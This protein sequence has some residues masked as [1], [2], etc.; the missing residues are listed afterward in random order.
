MKSWRTPLAGILLLVAMAPTVQG[1][2]LVQGA[3]SSRLRLPHRGAT[4]LDTESRIDANNIDMFVTNFGS[5]AYDLGNQASGLYYP[6]GS[7][8]TAVYAAGIW[9]GAKVNGEIRL[10][11]ATYGQE[12]TPGPMAG[13]TFQPDGPTFRNYKVVRDLNTNA[14]DTSAFAPYEWPRADGAPT[15]SLGRP[16]LLGDQM[17]WSVY[18]DADPSLH[19][20]LSGGTEPLGVEIQQSTFAFYNGAGLDNVVFLKYT[21][22]NKGP[23]TLDST[24]VS[25]WA[26]PDLGGFSDDLVGC[27]TTLSLGYCYNS[28]NNDAYYGDRP[29]AVGF[30]FF[31]G[32]IVQVSPGVYDTLGMTSFNKYTNGTDPLSA[33]E[34]YNYMSGLFKDGSPIYEYDN[35]AYPVTHYQVSGDPVAGD[36]WLDDTPGDRRLFLTSGP[37]TMAP[38]DTQVVVGAVIVGQGA[39]RLSSITDLRNKDRNAQLAFDTDFVQ[40]PPVPPP[41]VHA[42]PT[43]RGVHLAWGTEPVGYVGVGSGK[44]YHFEGFQVWQLEKNEPGADRR[45]LATYDIA[46]GVTSL[47]VD[48][49]NPNG[50]WQRVLKAPGADTGLEFSLDLTQDA[51]GGRLTNYREYYYAV[52]GYAYEI[53]TAEPYTA[54]KGLVVDFKESAILKSGIAV[55]TP[56]PITA[57]F[58]V[59]VTQTGGTADA[60]RVVGIEQVVQPDLTGDQYRIRF[61][62]DESWSLEN[63]T[64]G[65]TV[66]PSRYDLTGGLGTPIVEG[67]L[68]RISITRSVTAL[69]EVRADGSLRDMTPFNTDSTGVWH[70]ETAGGEPDLDRFVRFPGNLSHGRDYELRILPD[71]TEYAWEWYGGDPSPQATF[72]VPIEIWD[73]GLNSIA[74][75]SDDRKLSVMALDADGSGTFNWGDGVYFREI[76]YDSVAWNSP[77]MLSSDYVPDGSDQTLGRFFFTLDDSSFLPKEWPD[78]TTVRILN[79]KFSA[80]DQF[81]FR[82]SPYVRPGADPATAL[83]KILPVPNPYYAHSQYEV[84][85][86][87]RI[88]KFTNIPLD[89][90]VTIRIFNLAGDLVRTLRTEAND[91]GVAQT[92]TIVW[93]LDNERALPVAS[94]VYIYNVDIEGMG[95]KTDRLAVFIERERLDNY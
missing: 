59:P 76:P 42:Q 13:G 95:R 78:P 47:Y 9:L 22:I 31:R 81:E 1:A 58:T 8:N 93:D 56:Q 77:G 29:P 74:N 30:D 21:I 45:L 14:P 37:F 43:D 54:G 67:F 72:R 55:V 50:N 41:T 15:D 26:D 91:P 25:L 24:Y 80:A 44:E 86:F 28:N 27:D 71:T 62:D 90:R 39:D 11:V 73:L 49:T 63:L 5:Y 60:E 64:D 18:N 23:N 92:S 4:I 38:G 61:A 84:N 34:T 19:T 3:T 2:P 51:F 53:N 32:P 10:A 69:G 83:K 52:T 94:G 70:F 66:L 17:I 57:Q 33:V 46:D 48:E 12:F 82:T 20:D 7:S 75:P 6:S 16:A 89:R 79:R 35:L 68:P 40:A 88:V 87:N 36:G 65:A 85:Q